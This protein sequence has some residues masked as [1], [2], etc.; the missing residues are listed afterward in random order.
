MITRQGREGSRLY[1]AGSFSFA[2]ISDCT[3][4]PDAVHQ[5]DIYLTFDIDWA[6]DD[7]LA[8]TIDLVEKANVTATWFI[9]HNTPLLARLRAN[10][11]FELGVHPN[12]NYLLEGN[13]KN[14][15]DAEEVIDRVLRIVPEAKA[16]RCHS[17]TQN[18]KLSQL[19]VD[20]GFTHD[21]NHLI[22]EQSDISL[23][24]WRLWN[25]LIKV[26]HFWE[27]DAVCIYEVN[28]PVQELMSRGGLKVFDFH[29]I[30]IFLNTEKLERYERTRA[31]HRNSGELIKH[32]YAGEGTRTALKTLLGL[33]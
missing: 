23:K 29:P 13:P 20:K 25:G 16:I 28:T 5:S 18:S 24:P 21:C 22:P 8:D 33:P 12:F 2:K 32:R 30:H 17:M 26:P 15:R 27:D 31:F 3:V 4:S 14:G 7:V 10:Q 19:F 9:T 6:C 1:R 11:K